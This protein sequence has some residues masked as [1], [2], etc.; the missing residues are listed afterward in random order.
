[1]EFEKIAKRSDDVAVSW[2]G[3]FGVDTGG[4]D[5]PDPRFAP[6]SG[7]LDLVIVRYMSDTVSA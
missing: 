2:R 7:I 1:M 5:Y 3:R 4:R 6:I